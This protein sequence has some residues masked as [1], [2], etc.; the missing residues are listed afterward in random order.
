M[1]GKQLYTS[2]SLFTGVAGL[3]LALRRRG[4]DGSQPSAVGLV[5]FSWYLCFGW[6]SISYS[7]PCKFSLCFVAAMWFSMSVLNCS[8]LPVL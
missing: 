3:D 1:P 2:V 8:S 4:G 7:R 5:M 6:A